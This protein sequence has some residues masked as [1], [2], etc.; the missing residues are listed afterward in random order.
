MLR[1]ALA[2]NPNSGKTTLFNE[3]TGSRQFVGNWPGVTVEKKEGRL[4][5][6]ED[7]TI[8]DLPGIY[9]LSPYSPEELIARK[10]LIEEK[11]EAII[12][13][14]DGSNLERNLYLTTQ[15]LE[16]GIPVVLAV[17]MMDM[18]E[19]SGDKLD[20]K[21]LGELLG[22]PAVPISAL[23][24]RGIKELI[25]T[26]VKAAK[27]KEASVCE[28]RYTGSVEHALAHIEDSAGLLENGEQ[29]FTRFY[30]VKLFERDEKIAESL[31]LFPSKLR[32][33]EEDIV[34]VEKEYDNDSESIITVE[35]YAY[36]KKLVDVVLK[37]EKKASLSTS[38][39]IDKLVTNRILALPIFVAVI[40]L[41]YW[42]AMGP[43]GS[44]LTDWA[45]DGVFGDG[46]HLFGIG[47]AQY[48]E[49]ADAY[50]DS[51]LI[52]EAFNEAYGSEEIGEALDM[53]SED[54]SEENAL[55]ALEALMAATPEDASVSYEV[56]DEDTLAT[57]E[58][59]DVGKEELLGAVEAFKSI[60]LK[61]NIGA[62]DTSAYGIWVPG[63]P[64]LL[65]GALE[66]MD[67]APWLNGLIMDGI[68]AGLGA[69][70]GFVP[71]ML[72]L[73]FM[74]AFLEASGYMARIAFI[75]DRIFRKFGLSGKSFI[76]MLVG[77][78]CSVPGIMASRTIKNE[79]DRRMTIITT[80]FI[81]CGAKI[82]FI[83]MMAGAI[84]GNSPHI[85]S[86][87]YFI[88]M[89]AV[90]VSGIMLKKTKMFS[91]DS[92]PFVM[93]L[94]P[95]R[96]PTLLNMLRSMW[97]RGWSFIKKAGTII[98]LSTI[99]IWFTS[100][101]GIVEGAFRMLEE[102]ELGMSMLA[103]LGGVF[104]VLL[105]PLGF[106]NWQAA[107]AAIT[108]LV[109]KENI[110]GTMGILYSAEG[111]LYETLRA[112]FSVI[113]GFSFL[114]F[115]LLNAPCF[116]AIGAIKREMNNSRWTWFAIL[117]QTGFAYAISMIVYQLGSAFMGDVHIIE[118]IVS[119]A[120]LVLILY[121]LFRPEK[122]H[123]QE[124][125]AESKA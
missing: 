21:A 18:V 117:Y 74:L 71:Q 116:A 3:L 26:A 79:K 35:R 32:E 23:K 95:Y 125:L 37:R 65:G 41:V 92:D 46:W 82:P 102:D 86:L 17:N 6:H 76:P 66:A 70:L 36:I 103:S 69:V 118:L 40:Y 78:G 38:D 61:E 114:V 2:G 39:K 45:N 97:E 83:G 12:N 24:N 64:V 108:G 119:I 33:I 120:L 100:F 42:I 111:N 88:G 99:F 28:F 34:A 104:A 16:L 101:F 9:S 27:K 124:R 53:E 91:G 55:A 80:S 89:A 84:F 85:A 48:E 15:L 60:E 1:I 13:I 73:F 123:E 67:V 43:F 22:V 57:E 63:I 107:V 121:M 56:E 25:E 10:F 96:M 87:S 49:A 68:I 93:E 98:L 59:S 77:T 11:P 19:K 109:A 122:K 14:I 58:I 94:P 44:M 81:P 7:V 4:R 110:V 31:K 52:I 54:F 72:V 47:T 51:D 75:L 115:N 5:G 113:A 106:G 8:C 105:K 112:S 29:K 50:G 90:V 62:P 20:T 30:A